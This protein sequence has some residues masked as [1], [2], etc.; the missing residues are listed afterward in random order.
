VEP[1]KEKIN[2]GTVEEIVALVPGDWDRDGFRASALA[3]LDELELK[4]RIEQL[5]DALYAAL[6]GD[7]PTKVARI[8]RA[9]PAAANGN[10]GLAPSWASWPLCTLV[11]RHGL[12]HPEA[13]LDAMEVLTQHWSCEFAIRPYFAA[14]PE[15]VLERLEVWSRH[16]SAQVRRLVSEGSRPR[17]PWGIRLQHRIDHPEVVLP[18]LERLRDDPDEGV[19]RSVA[20]HLNG[21][22]KDHPEL[23][24]RVAEQWL[25]GAPSSRKKLVKHAL[26]TQIKAGEPRAYAL[27]GLQPFVGTVAVQVS[28]DR[29]AVGEALHVGLQLVSQASRPQ[30]VRLDLG[31][32]HRLKSGELSARVFHWTERTVGPGETLS[33]TK[34][35]PVRRVTTRRLYA[36]DQAIDV[37]VNGEP[38]ESTAFYLEV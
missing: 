29:I 24:L 38:T 1:F 23:V 36:G 30:R 35:Y 31:V 28:P 11:E 7:F 9:L 26:R 27:I 3:G 10:D 16:D 32:H 17:L 14:D 5:A 15:R 19:R 8:V 13:A 6:P 22:A 21:I 34:A 18:L 4:A 37:R 2:A 20:N 12:A 33:L 25:R